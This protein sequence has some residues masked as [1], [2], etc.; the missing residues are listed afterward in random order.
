MGLCYRTSK[1]SNILWRDHLELSQS[2]RALVKQGI[3]KQGESFAG[4]PADLHARLYLPTE[5]DENDDYP[6][7]AGKLH[8]MSIEL[9]EW[10]Q[11]KLMT[12]RNGFASGIAAEVM[13]EQLLPH[14]PDAPE[15]EPE[16]GDGGGDNEQKGEN[17]QEEQDGGETP[18][19]GPSDSDIRAALRKAARS[20][21]DAVQDAE[22]AIEGMAPG[23]G[24][25]RN[26]G[27]ADLKAIREAH[28][29][30]KNSDRLRKITQIAGRLERVAAS[31]RRSLVKPSVGEIHGVGMGDD[32]SRI[33]PSE[34]VQ[35]KH[36]KLRLSL[37]ARILEHRALSYALQGKEPLA[38]GPIVILLDES[39]SM[40][41]GGRD[42]WSKAVCLALLS[43]AT[44][45]RRA[46]CVI[47]FNG[48][49]IREVSIEP[50]KGTPKD[51]QDALDFGARGGT[52]FNAPVLRAME[53]IRT[54]RTMKKADVVMITDGEKNLEQET[55]DAARELTRD[56]GASW[57]V[58]GVGR[59][60]ARTV[61]ITLGPIAT[62]LYQVNNPDETDL[63][64][65]VINLE[66]GGMT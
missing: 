5:P 42:I 37:L 21:R 27:P 55:I 34:L 19:D 8:G 30:I 6:E 57:F 62:E 23:I 12:A 60:A 1:F 11:L 22:S 18:S 52:D 29:R 32:L 59:E 51:I 17:K 7:W 31:K 24:V 40:R 25:S 46:F 38:R 2:G 47:A 14:V 50:G 9:G 53:I 58:V 35:L 56:E 49:V 36:S 48:A 66:R 26:N 39:S 16:G 41:N 63:V 65:P 61:P 28:D 44:K 33:L 3:D 64:V 20:A 15:A 54:S 43:T 13:L 4:F 45:Q 10:H